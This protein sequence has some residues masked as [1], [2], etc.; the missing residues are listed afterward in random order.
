ML[1]AE[2][3]LFLIRRHCFVTSWIHDTLMSYKDR[4]QIDIPI[5]IGD[6]VLPM[7]VFICKIKDIKEKMK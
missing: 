5:D 7:E 2:F 1:Y 6:R 3:K 4:V